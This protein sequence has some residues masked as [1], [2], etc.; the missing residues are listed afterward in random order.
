MLPWFVRTSTPSG[1]QTYH[2]IELIIIDDESKDNTLEV[3]EQWR[4]EH[5]ATNVFMSIA[6]TFPNGRLSLPRNHSH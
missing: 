6:K 2:P 4:S 5:L 1:P 3:V